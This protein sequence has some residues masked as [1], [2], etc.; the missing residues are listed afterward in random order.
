[1]PAKKPKEDDSA[2]YGTPQDPP[3]APTVQQLTLDDIPEYQPENDGAS[4]N[5]S[6]EFDR[7]FFEQDDCS[8]DGE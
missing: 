2:A 6:D 8:D 1:M 4:E 5:E 7:D 3:V